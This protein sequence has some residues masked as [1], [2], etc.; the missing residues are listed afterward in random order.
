MPSSP[1]TPAATGGKTPQT[2]PT[3]ASK[4]SPPATQ[5][6]KAIA[7]QFAAAKKLKEAEDAKAKARAEAPTPEQIEAKS[8]LNALQKEQA[9]LRDALEGRRRARFE[10]RWTWTVW[11]WVWVLF[12]H[13]AGILVFTSGFLLSRLVLE[14][15]STCA[16]PPTAVLPNGNLL[17][18]KD[19][20]GRGTP[21]GGCWH[22]KTFS[23]AV[24]VLIDALRYDF[25]VPVDD[26]AEYHNA[27]PFM[28]RMAVE[29]PNN[30]FLRPFIADPPTATLQR[31]KGLTTGTLPTF[32]DLGSNFGGTA[33][34]EDNLLMQLRDVGRKIVHLGDDTWTTLFPGYFEPNISRAYDSFN[35]WDLHTVDAGVL[36]H[37][38]P[39][40]KPERKGEWDLVIGHLLGVDH[41]GH[42][43]GPSHTAMTA[44]LQQMDSFI[45]NLT[46]TIDDDTL[47]VVM[48]DHGMDSKGDHG[49]ESDDEVEAALWMYSSRPVF[50]RTNPEYSAPPATA[51]ERP[52]NQIDLV[53]TLAL[54]LGIPI[55]YNNLGQPI[56]E[57]F[58][59]KKG[60][61]FGSLA[62]ASRVAA[63]GLRRYQS[64]YFA[65]RGI[66]QAS[67]PG[68]PAE[69]WSSAEAAIATAG[70]KKDK[71]QHA[72]SLF[73]QYQAETL[74][75]C[76]GLWA[77]F[78]IPSM[79]LGILNMA[80]GLMALLLYIARDSDDTA[81]SP[82]VEND[83]LD[84]AER[85]LEL[86]AIVNREKDQSV[87]HLLERKLVQS[88]LVGSLPGAALG[89]AAQTL[90]NL[91]S[92][93]TTIGITALTS[94][95]AVLAALVGVGRKSFTALLP[96]SVWSWLSVVIVVSQSAGFASN[97]YT[98]WEDSITLFFL[99]TFGTLAAVSAF[100]LPGLAERTLGVYHGVLFVLLT[101]LASFSKLCREEQMPYCRSTYYAS[102]TSSTSAPWQLFI[103]L[104]VLAV[105]PTVIKA[106]MTPTKSYE[107]LAPTWIGL[108]L[109]ITLFLS[110][111]YWALDAV[112]NSG[113]PTISAKL[114]EG[115]L[116]SLS[117]Y[118]AQLTLAIAV[119]AGSTAFV[120]APPSVSILTAADPANPG[121]AQI[122]V[123]GYGNAHGARYL[124]LPLNI[125]S[126]LIIITK[127]VGQGALAIMMW[128][129]LS[130]AE[131][132]DLNNI[133]PAT[134]PIG[135]AILALL[136][137][138][139]FFKT[140]HQGALSSIQWDAAFVPLFSI[141]YP[142]SPLLVALNTFASHFLAAAGL[143]LL[144]LWKVN[145]K[146][147]GLLG[148]V[149][150]RV[151][152]VFV[153]YFAVQSLATMAWAA[154]LR[155]HLM[156][157]RVFSP[158]FMMAAAVLLLVDLAVIF[159]SL[160]GFR[161]NTLAISEVFGWAE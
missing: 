101:R 123:L 148:L 46:A 135:P 7:A 103:P 107:G 13:A 89:V 73:A 138:F 34:E 11:F 50:G 91:G 40:M 78:D 154:H 145:P 150:A 151:L 105:L 67:G 43:Y 92:W 155:R 29:K 134:S 149:S 79:I 119:I 75:I 133:T 86:E 37:I 10:S 66:A 32:I 47:L 111:F 90:M 139:H 146:R 36:E 96:S 72:Y 156:L 95:I 104:M 20:K 125:L 68:T 157:Y 8:R 18:I 55:P 33:I 116:K 147:K 97:S 117:V 41:A 12:I 108:V 106:Y 3:A 143:P 132:I 102:A 161:S 153:V 124:I 159:V 87:R 4:T 27:F 28:H 70:A 121:R 115:L 56:E 53:P 59:G 25:V 17:G 49:G 120:W 74:A 64:S 44:K 85:K 19:W 60:D 100:R 31:L 88:A 65:A 82:A 94:I 131:I 51:K 39:L 158:R 144:L 77:R 6:Y 129:M 52:V 127:P 113:W 110:C 14:E 35:V 98:I 2:H 45:Q 109:R 63:A 21:D 23:K 114:P 42:R 128:Q 58:A 9:K 83:D 126:A 54:L 93:K 1:K 61:A 80:L 160:F 136:A 69:V 22:P 142:W 62:A 118:I 81:G 130:L 57:A 15:K 30:A 112:D 24:V 140:G 48:G 76:K 152:A 122:T 16:E 26:Q 141:R 38:F 99:S 137:S 84:T 71:L 5:D